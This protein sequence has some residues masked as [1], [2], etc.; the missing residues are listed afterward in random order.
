MKNFFKFLLNVL[1]ILLK[2]GLIN[3]IKSI[4]KANYLFMLETYV[5]EKITNV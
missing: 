1:C 3:T 2:L 5:L 4:W